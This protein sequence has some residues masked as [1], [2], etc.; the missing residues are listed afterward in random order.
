M[1]ETAATATTMTVD[2]LATALRITATEANDAALQRCLDAADAECLA[3]VDPMLTPTPLITAPIVI[4]NGQALY[5]SV[6]LQRAVEWW[7]ANDAAFGIVGFAETG[8]LRAPRDGFARHAHA[9]SPLVQQW[10]LA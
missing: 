2:D 6:V 10:G 4:G 8:G 3:E 7:K 5:D 1:T 9:L